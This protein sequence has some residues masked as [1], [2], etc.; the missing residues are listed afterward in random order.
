MA[1]QLLSGWNQVYFFHYRDLIN[2]KPACWYGAGIFAILVACAF[3]VGGIWLTM[4]FQ[5]TEWLQGNCTIVR[6]KTT[7]PG[8]Q[9]YYEILKNDIIKMRYYK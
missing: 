6:N 7:M 5:Q 3:L 2:D 4:D 8:P 9:L 1:C